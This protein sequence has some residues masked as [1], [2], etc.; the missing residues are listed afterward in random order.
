MQADSK[1]PRRKYAYLSSGMGI[2]KKTAYCLI[3]CNILATISRVH[4]PSPK[5]NWHECAT[6]TDKDTTTTQKPNNK[7]HPYTRQGT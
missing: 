4:T 5:Q 6:Q 7:N 1:S 3:K 2:R